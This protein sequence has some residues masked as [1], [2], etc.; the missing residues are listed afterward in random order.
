MTSS[1]HGATLVCAY[2]PMLKVVYDSSTQNRTAAP[3]QLIKIVMTAA[4]AL[5]KSLQ[6]LLL[7]DLAEY[8]HGLIVEAL[9]ALGFVCISLR[10]STETASAPATPF[11]S[12]APAQ[13]ERQPCSGNSGAPIS[14]TSVFSS[15]HPQE[16]QPQER[17][18]SAT[19]AFSSALPQ[20][21]RLNPETAGRPAHRCRAGCESRAT[22]ART[23]TGGGRSG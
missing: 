23:G 20:K 5:W 9:K 2:S 11:P 14:A 7:K 17:L 12:R 19:S 15:A 6:R 13:R 4:A 16:R 3:D 22:S 10:A 1:L 21:R 8:I 18:P